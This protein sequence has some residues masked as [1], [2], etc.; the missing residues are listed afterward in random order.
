MTAQSGYPDEDN[1]H[2]VQY[3]GTDSENGLPSERTQMLLDNI[4]SRNPVRFIRKS[5]LK[6]EWAPQVGYR[7]DGLYDVKSFEILVAPDQPKAARHRFRLVRREGQDPIRGG[8][9]AAARPTE[10]E[11]HRYKQDK[12]F[13]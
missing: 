6:S 1:G 3:C 11:V 7:Y 4:K 5:T 10:Q 8:S 12:R 2:E 13:R 9:G